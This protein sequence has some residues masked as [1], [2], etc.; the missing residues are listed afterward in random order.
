MEQSKKQNQYDPLRNRFT[1]WLGKVMNSARA[2]YLEQLSKASRAVDIDS[3]PEELLVWEDRYDFGSEENDFYF[4]EKRISEAIQHLSE[5]G[6]MV[7]KLTYIDQLN[8]KEIGASMKC[9]EEAVYMQRSRA[10]AYLR[11]ALREEP[12]HE[13]TVQPGAISDDPGK[14]HLG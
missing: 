10:I 12:K 5:K 4:E 6:R 11:K 8:P 2:D 13:Q 9:T 3:L 14:G 1:A 7:L